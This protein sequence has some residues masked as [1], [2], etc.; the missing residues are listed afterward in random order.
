MYNVLKIL[1]AHLAKSALA[2]SACS[3]LIPPNAPQDKCV[4]LLVVTASNARLTLTVLLGKFA[5]Q[6]T[7]ASIVLYPQTAPMEEY[8]MWQL[9]HACNA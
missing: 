3:A 1:T 7:S 8:V 2:P 6:T 9:V 4:I 5:T